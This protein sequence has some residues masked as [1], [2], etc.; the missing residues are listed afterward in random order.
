MQ[1]TRFTLPAELDSDLARQLDDWQAGDKT[2]RL[3]AGDA[4]LWTGQDEADWLGW[5]TVIERSLARLDE[6]QALAEEVR[7]AGIRHVVLLGMGGSSMAPEVIRETLGAQPGF[8]DLQVLDSTNPDQLLA[9]ESSVDLTHTLFVVSSKSGSSLEPNILMDYFLTRVSEISGAGDAGRQFVAITDPGT[10]LEQ[11]AG[12]HNFRRVLHGEPAIGGRFSALSAF[13]LVPAALMGVDCRRLL[14]SAQAMATACA[15]GT[16]VA[17]NPGVRLGCVMGAAVL[18]GRDKLSLVQ[19]PSLASFGA[20]L[21]Q[22]VAE[23]TGKQGKSIIPVDGEALARPGDYGRDR[24]FVYLRLASA[25]D[26]EQDAAVDALAAAGQPVVQLEAADAHELGAAFFCWEIA[27]AVAGAIMEINPF[28]QPDVEASKVE[29]RRITAACEAGE[30]LP[31]SAALATDSGLAV[32]TDADNART[33]R[34]HRGELATVA[35]VIRAQLARLEEGDYFG[36]LAFL[37]RNPSTTQR[38]HALRNQ[39]LQAYGVATCLGFGPRFLHSTGQA[40]KGGVNNGVFVQLTA[41]PEN[42]ADVPGRSVS[43]GVVSSAQALGDFEV[44]AARGRRII[45]VHLGADTEVG[46]SQLEEI[47]SNI[48]Q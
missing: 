8:P 6:L 47:F 10:S 40:Y 46:L 2:A 27:T 13:G 41:D 9:V 35:E 29:A 31:A 30:A 48:K 28:D 33:L 26:A 44:M 38:L 3:W 12:E 7:A 4:T 19:S 24:L 39:V 14:Q 1:P 15:P 11:F 32:F 45:R 17:D 20:W 5:L 23:S 21:E 43:F 16:P 34:E 22:L 25:P 36:L 18:A 37:P 42:D